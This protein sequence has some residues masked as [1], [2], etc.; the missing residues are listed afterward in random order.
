MQVIL[1]RILVV[2]MKFMGSS[3]NHVFLGSFSLSCVD[4]ALEIIAIEGSELSQN[5]KLVRRRK[6]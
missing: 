5:L 3:C 6:D 1:I 4:M 2:G